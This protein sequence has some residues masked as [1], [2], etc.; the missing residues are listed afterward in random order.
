MA[1]KRKL[2]LHDTGDTEMKV[3]APK[4]VLNAGQAAAVPS[5]AKALQ[6]KLQAHYMPLSQRMSVIL[7]SLLVAFAFIGGW[8]GG[9]SGGGIA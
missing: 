8:L 2:D 4:P 6:N 5:P 7:V 9:S 3:P 1:A